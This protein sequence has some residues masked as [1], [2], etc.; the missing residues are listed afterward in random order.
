M[1]L[2]MGF[3]P[4]IE[5]HLQNDSN[6]KVPPPPLRLPAHSAGYTQDFRPNPCHL[7]DPCL[8]SCKSRNQRILER[9]QLS[10]LQLHSPHVRFVGPASGRG[11]SKILRYFLPEGPV[12]Y[13]Q[14]C[15]FVDFAIFN[16]ID[17]PHH[18]RDV[19]LPSFCPLFVS[20]LDPALPHDAQLMPYPVNRRLIL[21]SHAQLTPYPVN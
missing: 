16:G 4:N 10:P 14:N 17:P 11:T 6:R 13:S 20:M 12:N 1:S 7:L 5:L 2:P 15:N 8:I 18:F 19:S 3:S 21:S 9:K